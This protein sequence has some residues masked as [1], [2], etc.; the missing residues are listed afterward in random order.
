MRRVKGFLGGVVRVAAIVATAMF[1]GLLALPPLALVLRVSLGSLVDRLSRPAVIE[2]LRLSLTTSAIATGIVILLG[3]PTAYYLSMRRMRGQPLI[4]TLIDLPMVLPPTVAGAGLLFAFGRTGLAGG[5][6]GAFG[7]TIPFTTI[8]VVLAQVFVAA[9]FFIGAC[10]AGLREVEPRYV[11]LASTLRATPLFTFFRVMLPLS[12]PSFLAGA[13]MCWARALGEFG[14]TITF[15]GNLP[16]VT[17]TMPLAVYTALQSDLEAAVA[18]SVLMLVVSF[19]VLLLLRLLP[20]GMTSGRSRA[21]R[22]TG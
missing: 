22:R 13:A 21:A 12:A 18:L 19:V 2:A 17:Q 7:V 11:E 16:G 10:V 8:A 9:P 6:L 3:V 14:A 5:V 15:A 1:V 4:E 20:T